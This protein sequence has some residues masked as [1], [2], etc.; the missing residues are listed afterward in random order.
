MHIY[1][2]KYIYVYVQIYTYTLYV[3]SSQDFHLPNRQ[4]QAIFYLFVPILTC[5]RQMVML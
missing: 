5:P 2:H 3:C 4:A 1:I